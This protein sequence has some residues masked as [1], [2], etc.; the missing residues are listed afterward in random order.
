[1]PFGG[2]MAMGPL[3]SE[4]ARPFFSWLVGM[5]HKHCSSP[6]FDKVDQGHMSQDLSSSIFIFL[7]IQYQVAWQSQPGCAELELNHAGTIVV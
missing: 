3:A 2:P 5:G 1:M 4:A 6:C 7:F